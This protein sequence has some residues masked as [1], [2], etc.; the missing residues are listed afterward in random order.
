MNHLSIKSKK[1]DYDIFYVSYTPYH[2][3][4]SLDQCFSTISTVLNTK[5][6]IPTIEVAVERGNT[7]FTQFD[8]NN[9]EFNKSNPKRKK[10]IHNVTFHLLNPKETIHKENEERLE[11]EAL[12]KILVFFF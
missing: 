5:A 9:T 2:G 1:V 3:K 11:I 8:V 4:T 6:N 10:K 7:Q 12:T